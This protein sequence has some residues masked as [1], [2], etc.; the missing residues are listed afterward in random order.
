MVNR[1]GEAIGETPEDY[2]SGI[3]QALMM[4]NGPVTSDAID[5]DRSRLLRAVVES[6]FF[7]EDKRIE[8]LYLAVLTR[9]PSEAE[10]QSL[11]E[12]LDNKPDETTRRKAFG[13]ILWALL[14]SP[15]F[16]LCR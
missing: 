7:D 6:P 15:E 3:P 5:L 14:N 1:L 13:D 8:T 2:A 9:E 12:Y 10:K 11:T 16:V 4:M